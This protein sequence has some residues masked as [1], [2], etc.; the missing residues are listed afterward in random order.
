[1]KKLAHNI[2]I[3]DGDTVSFLGL[4]YSTRM[5]VIKLNCSKVWVHSPVK[6]THS[7]QMALKNIGE[8]Q[9]LIAP[10]HLHHLFL[11]DW[12]K[13]YPNAEVYGTR[14][15]IKKRSDI[16]FTGVLNEEN[17]WDWS[18]DI[19]QE[20]FSGSVLMQECVFFHKTSKTLIVTD[21]VENFSGKNFNFWQRVIAKSI[22][23]LAP[24]GKAPLDWRLSFVFHKTQA[25]KHAVRMLA[26]DTKILVIAHGE[27]VTENTDKFLSQSFKWLI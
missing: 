23:I 5:T 6:L 4:P 8:V 22:G 13:A 17:I 1:M 20:L 24:N 16:S 12:I 11:S 18:S 9:Y 14:E 3:F 7:I 21:L 10:N 26:W 2:W 15:V 19:A 27:I 25:R